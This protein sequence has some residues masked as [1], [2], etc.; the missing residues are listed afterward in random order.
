MKLI[1]PKYYPEKDFTMLPNK[2][3][4]DK[5]ISNKAIGVAAKLFSKPVGWLL[6]Y[7]EIKS[8]RDGEKSLRSALDELKDAGWIKRIKTH[9]AQ[10]KW[11]YTVILTNRKFHFDETPCP[12]SDMAKKGNLTEG[13]TTHVSGTQVSRTKA[14]K[15]GVINTNNTNTDYINM[16]NKKSEGGDNLLSPHLQE[17]SNAIKNEI[18]DNGFFDLD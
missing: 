10:G 4:N 13:S 17:K 1:Q 16:N 7:N 6:W 3:I 18:D 8:A 2:L 5:T 9:T 11:D 12:K 14:S 15:G